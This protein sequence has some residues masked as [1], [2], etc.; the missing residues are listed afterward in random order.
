MIA[1]KYE[2]LL[3]KLTDSPTLC[4]VARDENL[5]PGATHGPVI[6]DVY[7]VECCTAGY[8]S[9][10]INGKEFLVSPGDCYILLPG[11][12]VMHTADK[13]DP[14]SGVWCALSGL[15]IGRYLALAGIDSN[16]P[17]APESAFEPVTNIIEQLLLIKQKQDMGAELYRTSCIYNMI[18]VLLDGVNNSDTDALINKTIGFIEAQHYK[19]LTVTDL[20]NAVGLE[21]SYF[22]TVFKQKTGLSPHEYINRFRIQK[23]CIMLKQGMNS[24]AEIADAVGLDPQNFSR[25]FKK[26]MGM[27]P[28]AYKKSV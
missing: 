9:V 4:Y 8:G 2:R 16:N 20:A 23:A 21:R 27:S 7:I 26:E 10:I 1:I 6:R 5:A 3:K 24:V 13:K 15:E 14:R 11:D 17:Y 18:S 25:I 19:K 28:L 12:T 22:S